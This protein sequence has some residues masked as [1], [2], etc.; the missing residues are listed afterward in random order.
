MERDT[1]RREPIDL[2]PA[3]ERTLGAKGYSTDLVREI[4]QL[5]IG[6]D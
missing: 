2:G 1:K 4:P 6:D 3:S 5:G